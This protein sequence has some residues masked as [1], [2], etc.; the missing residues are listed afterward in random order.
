M[1]A[2][3]YVTCMASTVLPH[4]GDDTRVRREELTIA[5]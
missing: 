5:V 1:H 4:G 3:E 2:T